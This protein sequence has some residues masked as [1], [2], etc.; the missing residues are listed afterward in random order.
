M[1]SARFEE[2]QDLKSSEFPDGKAKNGLLRL[3]CIFKSDHDIKGDSIRIYQVD[4][5][6]F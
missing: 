1:V 5:I 4:T 3:N 6:P 2:M